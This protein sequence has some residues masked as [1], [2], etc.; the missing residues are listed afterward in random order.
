MSQSPV[1]VCIVGSFLENTYYID[2]G[3]N[4]LLIDPGAEPEKIWGTFFD[5][6]HSP[7]HS[8]LAT[9]GHFDH[10]GG[11]EFFKKK[12]D[13]PFGM[14]L[15]DKRILSQANLYRKISGESLF[16][17]TPQIDFEL[18][19]AEN[20]QLGGF[21]LKIYNTPGH[22]EGSVVIQMDK[23]LFCG[24]VILENQIGRTDLPGGD[25]V[26]LINSVK[27]IVDRFFG[28]RIYPG[29]GSDFILDEKKAELFLSLI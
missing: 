8:I 3:E 1:K 11:V 5:T 14:N 24:D 6:D 29:H 10:V 16:Y 15:R 17:P 23:I 27:F 18:G 26:K 22:S 12:Y 28:Y 4:S 9:H 13:V 2:N 19:N 21:D 20:V 7:L 25:K